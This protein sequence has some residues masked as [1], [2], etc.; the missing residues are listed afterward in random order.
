MALDF[1]GTISDSTGSAGTEVAFTYGVSS[2]IAGNSAEFGFSISVGDEGTQSDNDD[3]RIRSRLIIATEDEDDV[4]AQQEQ[5]ATENDTVNGSFTV[6]F[7]QDDTTQTGNIRTDEPVWILVDVD[8]GRD[9]VYDADVAGISTHRANTNSIKVDVEPQSERR[10]F[11]E[12]EAVPEGQSRL[13]AAFEG[14]TPFTI[15]DIEYER[16][17]NV[18]SIYENED[19]YETR[20]D[21]SILTVDEVVF[22]YENPTVAIDGAGRFTKHQIIGGK[23]VRQKTGEDPL[24]VSINGVCV[25]STANKIDTLRDARHGTINS[26]R[27]PNG[28]GSLRVQF[29][30]TS[31][32]PLTDGGA[33]KLTSGE[34]LYTYTINCIEVIR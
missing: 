21:G 6:T 29:G 30:S 10:T 17:A 23:T 20:D 16:D 25:Q 33:A 11:D 13:S 31:T 5:E 24:N 26:E 18:V 9:G 15:S 8:Y 2:V 22:E 3:V 7:D 14:R 12:D 28:E 4:T 27:L 1:S 19:N 34:L 32:E